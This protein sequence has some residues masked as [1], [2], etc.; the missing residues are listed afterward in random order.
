MKIPSL[1]DIRMAADRIQPYVHHTPVLSSHLVDEW[2]GAGVFFKCENFQRVGAFKMRGAS[3]VVFSLSEEVAQK[4]VATHSSGNHAQALALAARLRG[5]PAWIVMPENAPEVK[6]NAVKGYGAE[7][8]FCKPTLQAREET[9]KEVVRETGSHFVPP[10]DDP[11]IIAGQGTAALELLEQQPELDIIIAPVGGGGL[12]CGTAITARSQ[13]PGITVYGAEPAGADDAW[14]SYHS[15]KLIPQTNP[16]TIADGL[17]TSLSDLTFEIIHTHLDDL[18][19]VS[20]LGIVEAM[21]FIW[22]RM[23]IIIEPSSAVPVAAMHEYPDL[24]QG[25]RV[26]IILSGGNVDLKHLPWQ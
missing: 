18:L 7:I 17:R 10:Y 14:Q 4:G 20:E 13:S 26:G 25:K 5:I 16:N 8:R 24:F 21:R 2:L 15:G 11:R 9:L 3:N 23:K 1:K 22:E 12:M 19:R 6:R